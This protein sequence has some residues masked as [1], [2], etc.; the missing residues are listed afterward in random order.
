[1]DVPVNTVPLSEVPVTTGGDTSELVAEFDEAKAR[2][3][4]L[5]L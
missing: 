1:M 3:A 2:I 5:G 4:K